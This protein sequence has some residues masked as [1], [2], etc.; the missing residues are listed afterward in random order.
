MRLS[1]K[2][3]AGALLLMGLP[4]MAQVTLT[5]Q[6]MNRGEYRHG[7]QKLADTN[8]NPAV[9]ISQRARL[10]GEYKKEKYKIVIGAQD[11]RTWGSVANAA[12]DTKGLLSISEAY[13][14]VMPNK[15]ISVKFGRQILSYDDDR[16][17]GSLDWAMQARRHDAAIFRYNDSTLTVHLGGAFNQNQEQYNTTTYSVAN[18][19]KTFQFLWANKVIGAANVSFLF[20]NNGNQYNRVNTNGTTDS[21]TVF[22]QT[23]GLRGVYK[24]EKY[25]I[26]GYGYYQM[27]KDASN[28][29][30]S[31]YDVSAEVTYNI[32]KKFSTTL[33]AELL[34]GTS[35]IDTA[36]KVNHSFSPLYGTNHRFNGYMDYFYVGNHANSVGLL[37]GFFKV[38]YTHKNILLGLNLHAFYAAADIRDKKNTTNLAAMSAS[39]GNEIDFTLSYK[40][41]DDVALQ[42]GYSQILATDSMVALKAGNKNETS[43]WAYLM[44]IIRPGVKW[45]KTGLKM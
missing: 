18:N 19:Y 42:A 27:G 16:I 12:L 10:T 11:I 3:I 17:I 22:S 37:D 23:A 1:K 7:F 21:L 2:I 34:S 41:S 4:T 24:K 44:V 30:L 25:S 29:D 28:K 36:N 26:S 32:N 43:N 33:G 40:I 45:P 8:Q 35:Q 31:A 5:P 15:N 20:L 39:L 14:E 9:F 6:Y 38:N 13:G